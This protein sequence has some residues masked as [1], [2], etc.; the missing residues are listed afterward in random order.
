MKEPLEVKTYLQPGS[1]TRII[2]KRWQDKCWRFIN[3]SDHWQAG[4]QGW[5]EKTIL[6]IFH[7]WEVFEKRV[8]SKLL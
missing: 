4:W 3:D 6:D 5:P 7:K 8:G 2:L 1:E